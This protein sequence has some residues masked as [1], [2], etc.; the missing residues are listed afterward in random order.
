MSYTI[1]QVSD[2][3]GIS[4]STLRYYDKEGLLPFI[5]RKENYIDI[6]KDKDREIETERH[7]ER[8]RYRERDRE[9]EREIT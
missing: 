6:V 2:M 3:M 7:R 1:K 5:E 9:R 4:V 8:E